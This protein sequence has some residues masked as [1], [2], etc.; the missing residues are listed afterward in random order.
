MSQ[1]QILKT[2]TNHGEV[3]DRRYFREE[4]IVGTDL[5]IFSAIPPPDYM[6][7]ESTH[8]SPLPNYVEIYGQDVMYDELRHKDLNRQELLSLAGAR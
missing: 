8:K 6:P 2:Y 1:N 4:T 3:F 7:K 5:P